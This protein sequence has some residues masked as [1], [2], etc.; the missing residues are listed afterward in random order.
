M[1][2]QSVG[3]DS[4]S[5]FRSELVAILEGLNSIGSLPQLYDIWILSDSRSAI[6]N[7]TNWNNVMSGTGADILKILKRLSFSHQIHFQWIPSHVDIA[8]NEIAD[9]LARA[10][11]KL[12]RLP[13]LLFI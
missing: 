1:V 2:R 9:S 10:G 12:Q 5:V 11:A 4:C 6:Q 3:L 13:L 7:L 8:G